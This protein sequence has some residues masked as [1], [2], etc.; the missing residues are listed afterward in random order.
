MD[1]WLVLA[2]VISRKEVVC[3]KPHFGDRELEES[4]D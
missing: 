4:R 1:K 3:A 2:M